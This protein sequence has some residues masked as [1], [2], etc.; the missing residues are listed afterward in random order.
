LSWNGE[1]ASFHAEGPSNVK[2]IARFAYDLSAKPK[3]CTLFN[4]KGKKVRE[5]TMKFHEESNTVL[6]RFPAAQGGL[7]LVF[8]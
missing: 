5:L 3:S 7:D 4:S 8:E 6:V 1:G 2:G